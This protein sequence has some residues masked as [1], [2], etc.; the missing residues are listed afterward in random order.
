MMQRLIQPGAGRR[1][2][3]G[4][5]GWMLDAGLKIRCRKPE[6]L[7]NSPRYRL[8]TRFFAGRRVVP[9]ARKPR[10]SSRSTIIEHE[11]FG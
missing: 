9:P 2:D 10:W 7:R 8:E 6:F 4:W 3:G 1:L 11:K 5:S